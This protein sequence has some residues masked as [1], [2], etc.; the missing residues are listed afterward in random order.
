MGSKHVDHQQP[1]LPKF[2]SGRLNPTDS[3]PTGKKIGGQVPG[4]EA[5]EGW[6]W[7]FVGSTER[8]PCLPTRPGHEIHVPGAVQGG[9]YK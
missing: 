1:S 5:A 6:V 8:I 4:K 2:C 3:N 9:G 7:T